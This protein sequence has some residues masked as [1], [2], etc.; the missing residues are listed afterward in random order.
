MMTHSTRSACMW[1]VGLPAHCSPAYLPSSN[2]AARL[3]CLRAMRQILNQFVGISVVFI[4]DCVATLI[5]LKIVDIF[6]GLRVSKDVERDGLD[7][8]LRGE[9][10]Q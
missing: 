1:W 6:I 4:Y 2:T 9:T 8:A 10:M 3:A 5:I 7:L